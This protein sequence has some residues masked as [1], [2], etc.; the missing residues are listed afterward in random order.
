MRADSFAEQALYASV[1]RAEPPTGT[2]CMHP[3]E[4]LEVLLRADPRYCDGAVGTMAPYGSGV[5][6]LPG[7]AGRSF[8]AELG[9]D[10]AADALLRLREVML[11]DD[12]QYA[13]ELLK[14]G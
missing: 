14:V 5:L 2:D 13:S 3:Q 11:K 4:A 1:C 6:S 7:Q 8:A 10:A 9:C 12:V